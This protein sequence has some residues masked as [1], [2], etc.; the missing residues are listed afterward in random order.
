[1]NTLSI[2]R[3]LDSRRHNASPLLV[4]SELLAT[5]GSDGLSEALNNGWIVPDYESGYLA[6]NTNLARL[7]ELESACRCKKCGKK[8]CKCADTKEKQC[9]AAPASLRE[10]WSGIGLSRPPTSLNG[11]SNFVPRS[12]TPSI[13]SSE[14]QDKPRIGDDV[15]VADDGKSYV[16]K[17]ASVSDDGRYRLSF[18]GDK[19]KMDREYN[20]NEVRSLNQ[21]K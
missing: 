4:K 15:T 8:D 14:P 19:P 16:G 7:A 6:I 3:A 13:S 18:A 21:N 2:A 1:M 9:A 10:N 11:S 12:P 17:I 20:Q 5:I